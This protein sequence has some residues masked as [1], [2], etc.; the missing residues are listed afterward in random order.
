[1]SGPKYVENK[2]TGYVCVT[3]FT[4]R[5]ICR[6]WECS[7]TN[8]CRLFTLVSVGHRKFRSLFRNRV[9]GKTMAD[10]SNLAGA[11]PLFRHPGQRVG[12]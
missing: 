8:L 12:W 3:P 7:D 4:L 5:Q 10:S 11:Q 9:Y 2:V 1:M 6:N